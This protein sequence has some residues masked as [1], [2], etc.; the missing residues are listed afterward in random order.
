MN[1]HGYESNGSWNLDRV[2][3]F[4]VSWENMMKHL[5]CFPLS[6][7]FP[8]SFFPFF[9]SIHQYF[10]FNLRSLLVLWLKLIQNITFWNY[11]I[12]FQW[13]W[14]LYMSII[15]LD[16]RTFSLI[17]LLVLVVSSHLKMCARSLN[18]KKDF[19]YFLMSI[20]P[21]TSC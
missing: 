20:N 4:W 10:C 13:L 2:H 5:T 12:L 3:C 17:V 11:C 21:Q 7:F 6:P 8:V 1:L 19:Q 9:L 18:L 14:I 15:I 16:S